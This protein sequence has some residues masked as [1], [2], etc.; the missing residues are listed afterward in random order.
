MAKSVETTVD[1]AF[2]TTVNNLLTAEETDVSTPEA[3]ISSEGRAI[4][5]GQGVTELCTTNEATIWDRSALRGDGSEAGI[6]GET[7]RGRGEVGGK[8]E[9]PLTARGAEARAKT[10]PNLEVPGTS[11]RRGF[12]F[13]LGIKRNFRP[14]GVRPASVG[15]KS[16]QMAT[17]EGERRGK[18]RLS[19]KYD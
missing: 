17:S 1:W 6:A 9:R 14:H 13:F 11:P 12:F 15:E 19:Q 7:T 16:F 4:S 3:E 10:A 2:V 8:E 18:P 5:E